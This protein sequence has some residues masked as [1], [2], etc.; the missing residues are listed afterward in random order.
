MTSLD[1]NKINIII[2]FGDYM[3]FKIFVV[4]L[5][6]ISLAGIIMTVKDKSAAGKGKWRIPEKTLM[7]TGLF[8]AAL[9]MLI[10]MKL[11]RHKTKHLKFMLG[12][13]LEIVL[14]IGLTVLYFYFKLR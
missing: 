1:K 7:L 10:T 2:N 13:P 8:G 9:P 12:L 6:I 11:I 4:Y 14:H 3:K 5:I